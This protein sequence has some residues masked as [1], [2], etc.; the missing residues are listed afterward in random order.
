MPAA[1]DQQLL[2]KICD[3]ALAA[4]A[5]IME[6]YGRGFSVDFKDDRSPLTEA[7]H[8]SHAIIQQSLWALEPRYPILS[9]ESDPRSFENRRDWP[10]YWLVDPLDGTKE[11]IK[12]NGEF[13]VNIALIESH[14][15]IMGVVYAPALERL[16]SGLVGEGAWLAAGGGGKRRIA[17]ESEARSRVRVVG[18][19]SHA[20]PA[21]AE[22]LRHIGEHELKSMGSSLKICLVAEGEAD[23]Y[24]R[25]GPTSEWDTAA[26]H[27]ILTSAGGSMIAVDGRPLRYNLK[28]D[29]LNPHFLAFGDRHRNWLLGL[30]HHREPKD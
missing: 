11:F 1:N 19:R 9:E 29:L 26:A 10:T 17:V 23:V 12:R 8:A 4:G 24:P 6:I 15:P 30:E 22:Y 3:I 7:D 27:A 13:T 21:L 18:S 28:A 2:D 25:L 14:S 5:A 16:Y 20:S